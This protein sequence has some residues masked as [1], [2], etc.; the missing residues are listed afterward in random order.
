MTQN[1]EIIIDSRYGK[2]TPVKRLKT[3]NAEN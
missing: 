1:R 2:L 3:C